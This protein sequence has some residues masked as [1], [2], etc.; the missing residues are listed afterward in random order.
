MPNYVQDPDDSKKQVLGQQENFDHINTVLPMTMSK[1]PN[2]VM[3]NEDFAGAAGFFFGTSASFSALATKE[4]HEPGNHLTGSL[5]SS[6]HYPLWGENAAL[7]AGNRLDIH[8]LAWSG[9]KADKTRL[10]FVYKGGLDGS[11]RY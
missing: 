8:P 4:G 5:T 9:S 3:V 11:G 2:Y 6:T 10:T 1:T 7:N